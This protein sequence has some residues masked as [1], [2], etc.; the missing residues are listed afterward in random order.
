[1]RRGRASQLLLVAAAGIFVS[2]CGLTRLA[3][4][5]ITALYSNAAP[6]LT[7]MVDDYVDIS[8]DQKD[9]V[10][11]HLAHA[12]A[13]HRRQELPEYRR[14][15]ERVATRFEGSFT[16]AEVEESY[17]EM[18]AHYRKA[19]EYLLPD[20]AE[21]L[22]Q[23]DTPQLAQ[24][25]RKFADENRKMVK[26][27]VRGSPA[28]RLQE[29]AKRLFVHI[30]EWTGE[31]TAEQ[32]ELVEASLT[33]FADLTSERLADRRYRQA[34]MLELLRS[35]PSKEQVVVGLHRL[36]ID[37]ELWRRPEYQEALRSRDKRMYEMVASLSATLSSEQ[38]EHLTR[39]LRD[40]IRDISTLTA[41]N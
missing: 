5:N 36:L 31:L 19:V 13:W 33:S 40:Y 1:M 24:L 11:E 35:K 2:A 28:D 20:V 34:Q 39:R 8:G 38:R 15:L 7:W 30:Q 27:S 9:W 14:F 21:F 6:M 26:E 18:R 12:L 37:T 23:L 41:A 4:N 29:R 32:R 22:L 10:R 17:G 25:E 16:A 3:Y